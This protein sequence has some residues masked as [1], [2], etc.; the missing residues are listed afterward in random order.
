MKNFPHQ[1]LNKVI[2]GA[3]NSCCTETYSIIGLFFI[4]RETNN[5]FSYIKTLFSR[6][7][8]LLIK[9]MQDVLKRVCQIVSI[10]D[11]EKF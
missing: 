10:Q 9:N 11:F 7:L 8:V 5:V 3:P 1:I 6:F 4:Q 2:I